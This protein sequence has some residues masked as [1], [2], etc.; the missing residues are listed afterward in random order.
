[1]LVVS[2][3]RGESHSRTP[4]ARP[5]TT[6]PATEPALSRARKLLQAC[7]VRQTVSLHDGT[8]Y[9]QLRDGTRVDLPE[10][11][12]KAIFVEVDRIPRSCPRVTSSME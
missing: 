3:C 10:R 5:T 2:G 4:V 1:M 9:L 12:Q 6:A 11:L 7:K 8:F